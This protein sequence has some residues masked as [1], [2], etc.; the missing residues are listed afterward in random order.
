MTFIPGGVNATLSGNTA[1]VMAGISSGTLTLA[2]GNNITL[3]QN[4]NAVT[5]SGGAGGGAAGTN[6]IGMSNLGNTTGTSGVISGS[7]LQFALAG[8]NNIT[9]S[10]SI[11]GSSA[12]ITISTPTQTVQTQSLVQ[13][14]YDGANSISTGTI[15]LSNSNGMSFG[16]NGQTITGSHNGITSQTNQTVGLYAVSNTTQSS[17]V[18]ADARSLSFA[19]AGVASVGA[20]NG[21]V[22]ISVPAGGGGGFSAGMSTGGNTSGNTGV[23]TNQIVFAG[24]NNITLSQSTAAGGNTI[25]ISGA[26]GGGGGAVTL[27]RYQNMDRGTSSALAVPV[28]TLMLQRLNQENDLFAGNITAQ[29]WLMNM[30]GT[31]SS[32]ASSTQTL[33]AHSTTF[34]IGIYQPVATANS[35]LTLINSVSTTFGS[36]ATMSIYPHYFGNRWISI[37][38]SQWSSAPAFTAGGDYVFGIVMNTSGASTAMS[39]VGQNYM[40]SQVRSGFWGVS[41]TSGNTTMPH[42]NYW[43]AIYS[44]STSAM[45]GNISAGQINRANAS[46]IFIPHIIMNNQYTY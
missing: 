3:S 8:G 7:N 30:S 32:G 28:G 31:A 39:Y 10:Q 36:A 40:N 9:L 23:A 14:F 46:A 45:P 38:S 17:S 21:S 35:V 20:T 42:G 16:I 18:T 2:G 13:A 34:R 44:A 4:G 6:T 22:L 26:A 12:T 25:T 37:H 1:G 27:S 33:A 43:N 24:G 19:G 41:T 15:R 29:T 5:I 11:N